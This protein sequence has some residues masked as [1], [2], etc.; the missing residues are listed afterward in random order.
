LVEDNDINQIVAAEL[1]QDA[2]F[3]V[4]IA[5]NGQVALDRIEQGSYDLV[6]MDMQMPVMDG[7]AATLEIRRRDRHRSLP[8]I[9]MTANAMERDRQKCLDAGMND[10]L[11]KPIEPDD[12]WDILLKWLTD[13]KFNRVSP[14]IAPWTSWTSMRDRENQ[15]ENPRFSGGTSGLRS[16]PPR[17]D[18]V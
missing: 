2:G 12:V 18:A 15:H 13:R 3:V 1:L 8:V 17:N 4:D 10:F 16:S 11:S 14:S 9:A 6:L 5:E 7:I